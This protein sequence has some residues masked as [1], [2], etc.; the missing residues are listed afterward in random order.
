MRVKREKAHC[1]YCGTNDNRDHRQCYLGVYS[2]GIWNEK[3]RDKYL[4]L[5]KPSIK[6]RITYT[7]GKLFGIVFKSTKYKT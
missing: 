7:I 3:T 2:Q 6:K 1:E 4:E 5:L